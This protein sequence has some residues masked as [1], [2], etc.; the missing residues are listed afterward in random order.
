M[1]KIPYPRNVIAG[2]FRWHDPGSITDPTALLSP[3][4]DRSVL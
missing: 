2:Y 3:A 4:A 1:K